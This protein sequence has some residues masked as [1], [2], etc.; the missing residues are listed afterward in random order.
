MKL[1]ADQTTYEVC[2]DWPRLP[3]G[4]H[5]GQVPGVA[6]DSQDRIYVFHRGRQPVI[7]LSRDG[8]VL[9]SWGEGLFAL[10][11]GVTI[12][13]DDSLYLVDRNN[14][15]VGKFSP[16]GELL[17]V[18][19][20]KGEASTDGR[21]FNLPTCVAFSASGEMYVSDGYGASRVHKFSPDGELVLSWGT[22]GGGPGEFHLPHGVHVDGQG[23][24]YV[25]DRE[26]HRI[27]IFTSEGEFISEWTGFD[28]PNNLL[29]THDGT[30]YV[31]E[32]SHRLSILDS[33]WRVLARWDG[34]DTKTPGV[35]VAPHDVCMDS[36][37]DLY[38]G[39]VLEGK[40]IQKLARR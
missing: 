11:H 39:E 19:G 27:Q 28:R 15:T 18:F 10:P 6:V 37:G 3:A 20:T 25:A 23:R 38:V 16:K 17:R 29:I 24:V 22:E 4:W 14:H 7:V 35:F 9:D 1:C 13:P 5:V 12:G 2:D 32:L 34:E 33:D 40:R 8:E 26:N 36:H 21:P 31:P 30:V